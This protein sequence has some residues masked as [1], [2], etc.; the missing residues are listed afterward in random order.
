MKNHILK[1]QLDFEKDELQS[2]EDKLN[3]F[4]TDTKLISTFPSTSIIRISSNNNI[5]DEIDTLAEFL[6]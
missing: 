5:R 1:S 4:S 6:M 2:Y 3:F